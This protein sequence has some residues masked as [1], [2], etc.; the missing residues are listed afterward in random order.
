M[1]SSNHLEREEAERLMGGF[2][3]DGSKGELLLRNFFGGSFQCVTWKSMQNSIK[4]MAALMGEKI[5]RAYIRR[6]GLMI[7]WVDAHA[8][9]F[10]R[11]MHMT[12]ALPVL[13]IGS[14]ESI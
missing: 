10:E 6:K 3:V 8:E 11:A 12:S 2:S 1:R 14:P 13:V 9:S 5:P 4:I 7:K